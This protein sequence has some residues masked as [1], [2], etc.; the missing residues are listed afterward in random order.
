MNNP[1]KVKP[2]FQVARNYLL[3]FN[4]SL[5]Q[6]FGVTLTA[7][8]LVMGYLNGSTNKTILLYKNG[9]FILPE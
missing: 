7:E 9:N 6:S 4:N 3:S 1:E 8:D 5:S 2:R